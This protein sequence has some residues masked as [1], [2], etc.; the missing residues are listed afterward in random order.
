MTEKEYLELVELVS[1]WD[2]Q[3]Y[4]M[5]NPTVTDKKYDEVYSKLVKY[6]EK[7]SHLKAAHSP[8]IRVGGT[9]LSKMDK[10][11][12]TFRLYSLNKA[13]V[14][15]ELDK[16]F[17]DV[18][19]E[20]GGVPEYALEWKLDGLSFV[21]RYE[22]GFYVEARTRGNGKIGE[23]VTE[24]VKT[25]RNM[26]L[27]IPF[28]GVLEV[29]GEIIIPLDQFAKYN[30]RLNN[31]LMKA[32]YLPDFNE[33]KSYYMD[34]YK[35]FKNP[36]NAAA[37]ALR[38]LNLV[39]T[40]KRPLA[41]YLYNIG[42][43]EGKELHTQ[44]EMNAFLIE[45]GFKTAPL[46]EVYTNTEDL[47]KRVLELSAERKKQNFEIDGLVIKVN[48]LSKREDLG[49][50]SKFPKG[51]I[52][53]KFEA[54]EETT[55][56]NDVKWE[57]GRTGRVT[58]IAQL[59]PVDFGGVVVTKATL[60]NLLDI[61]TK[62]VS[63]GAEVFIRRSNDVIPEIMGVVPGSV[64]TPIVHPVTCPSCGE[65]TVVEMPFVWCRNAE[66]C[67]AQSVKMWSHFVS[68]DAMNIDGLSEKTLETML[69]AKKMTKVSDMFYL[70][71]EDLME[72]DRFGSKKIDNLLESIEK[73][74]ETTWEH[75]LYALGI[76]LVGKGTAERTN[77][78]FPGYEELKNAT[79]EQLILIDDVGEKVA[80][81]IVNYFSKKEN[82]DEIER[83]IEAGVTFK[84][85]EK[86]ETT[87]E[88]TDKIFVLTGKM[89]APRKEME[90]KIKSMGGTIGS[91][92]GKK[93]DFLI[94]GDDAGSKLEKA[95]K[96]GVQTI[97]EKDFFN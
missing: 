94:Y 21:A 44:E 46:L 60:N 1:T 57:V 53:Y 89:V 3:Y 42:H 59:E 52:A 17:K 58:P 31:E 41:A 54:T 2:H 95:A 35:P 90:E 70:K 24:Q 9:I 71:K 39:E 72:L 10:K 85:E 28:T 34:L 26:P 96:L 48:D 91:S 79:Y 6:E 88:Y 14:V 74:K 56:L 80:E 30:L 25:I 49:H 68:R 78:V 77:K 81:E 43:I 61:E 5:D 27:R 11:E 18:L 82:L 55:T 15:D 20:V 64:G 75:F 86:K 65:P 13:Q 50:T 7:N 8:T 51:A 73:A 23:I 84:V 33:K 62:G 63:I 92:V 12:H 37:G 19:K 4:T 45:N 76:N 87:G 67:T 36:R 69:M 29:Q 93:T 66:N 16:F 38:Q 83:M 40:A 47:K 32:M 97:A 22:N